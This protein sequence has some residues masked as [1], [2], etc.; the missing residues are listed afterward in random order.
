MYG[1]KWALSTWPGVLCAL[2]E[3]FHSMKVG[4]INEGRWDGRLWERMIVSLGCGKETIDNVMEIR[5]G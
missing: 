5:D 2:E 4:G 1:E 3:S